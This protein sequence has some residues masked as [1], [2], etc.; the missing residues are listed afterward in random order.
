MQKR[1]KNEAQ[2]WGTVIRSARITVE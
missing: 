1:M 2:L